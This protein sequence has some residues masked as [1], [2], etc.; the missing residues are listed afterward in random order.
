MKPR[1]I[2]SH[3]NSFPASTYKVMLDNL[4]QRGFQVDAVEMYGHDPKYPVSNNWPHLVEQLADFARDKQGTGEPAFLIGHSLGGILSLMCAARHPELARGVLL[5]D[6]P[7]LGGWRATTVG[8]AKRTPLI[9]ALSPG[10][11]SQKRRNHWPDAQAA[12]ESFAHKKAF[13]RWDPQ[14]LRDYIEHGTHDAQ[15]QRV[16]SFDRD[17]ETAIYNCLPHKLDSLLKRHPLKCPAAFIGGTH[18]VEMQQAGKELTHKVVKGRIM[19]LDGSHLFPMEKPLATAAA[20]EASLR[21]I[22]A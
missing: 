3:G 11:I 13:A 5:I 1:I 21:N 12:L 14:V 10:R 4:R 20:I 9:G 18:S 6:S 17:V 8:L 19:M 2:F 15:G 22:G 7:V 16:L